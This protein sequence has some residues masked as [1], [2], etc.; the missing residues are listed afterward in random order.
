MSQKKQSHRPSPPPP[1]SL[2]LKHFS[3]FSESSHLLPLYKSLPS[4]LL[5]SSPFI[6]FRATR[7]KGPH[8][9]AA[10]LGEGIMR[11]SLCT[12]QKVSFFPSLVIFVF[13][14]TFIFICGFSLFRPSLIFI[15]QSL[16]RLPFIFIFRLFAAHHH[17]CSWVDCHH[18]LVS[19]VSFSLAGSLFLR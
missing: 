11:L 2:S 1:L 3:L 16:P 5:C 6:S 10:V 19:Q 8:L 4:L 13:P 18:Y 14:L 7:T 12:L 15:L 17:R 9:T